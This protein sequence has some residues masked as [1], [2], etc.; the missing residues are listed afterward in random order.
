MKSVPGQSPAELPE[1]DP[2]SSNRRRRK[3]K[4][5]KSEEHSWDQSSPVANRLRRGE[6]RQ[7]L[8]M[9]IGGVTLFA[10][11]VAGVLFALMGGVDPVIRK[12][13]A[14]GNDVASEESE[15]A[16][17]AGFGR[18]DA[19]FLAAAE[20][21]TGEFLD[22]RDVEAMLDLVHDPEVAE[23]RMKAFYGDGRIHAPGM[24]GFNV[25][26]QVVR[27][28][29][30][31]RLEVRTGD[32]EQKSISYVES[33]DSIK[34]DWES[35]VGWSEMKWEDFL[36]TKPVEGRVF[37]LKLYPIEYYNFEFSDDK[38]WKS[39]RLESPDGRYSIY[40]YVESESVL[41]ARLRPSP[42][43]KSVPLMLSLKF[44]ENSVSPNQ[45][46]IEE[47]VNEGWVMPSSD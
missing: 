20:P 18:S 12:P 46:V 8:W 37:R 31:S 32:F 26:K 22:A 2:K 33:A 11:L 7:M 10:L 39:Y 6:K 35:W 21:L 15:K 16:E 14:F 13:L 38:K 43:V 9:L 42:D 27:T 4:G 29:D 3:K 25:A 34:I 47:I 36:E 40:G 24:S 41:N 17:Q 1:T 44:P 23:A 5:R 28:G 19:Q 30:I 45:V